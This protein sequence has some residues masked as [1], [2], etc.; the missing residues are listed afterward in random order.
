[1]S[2]DRI[3][4][5][6]YTLSAMGAIVE[7][8]DGLRGTNQITI[9]DQVYKSRLFKIVAST[10]LT[11]AMYPI[12]VLKIPFYIASLSGGGTYEISFDFFKF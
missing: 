1:M 2:I 3:F 10:F 9:N 7:F 11:G 4:K 5:I 8:Y 12:T 6:G